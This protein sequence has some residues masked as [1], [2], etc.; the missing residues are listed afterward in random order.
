[1]DHPLSDK[2]RSH[3]SL[4]LEYQNQLHR[5]RL[6]T[7]WELACEW[8]WLKG[9]QHEDHVPALMCHLNFSSASEAEARLDQGPLKG[10]CPSMAALRAELSK[11]AITKQFGFPWGRS[12]ADISAQE[13]KTRWEKEMSHLVDEGEEQAREKQWVGKVEKGVFLFWSKEYTRE[14][15]W[16]DSEHP[17]VVCCGA[18]VCRDDVGCVMSHCMFFLYS[19]RICHA[20]LSWTCYQGSSSMTI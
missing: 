2:P 7:P 10:C 18:N 5:A 1:M 11:R 9:H 12:S 15:R 20:V 4:F 14:T 13:M 16:L 6:G 3:Y 19:T 8:H 17:V